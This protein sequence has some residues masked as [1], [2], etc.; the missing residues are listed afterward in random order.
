M[1]FIEQHSAHTAECGV[2]LQKA[3]EQAIG[4]QLNPG[5]RAHAA[6]E[7]H[8]IADGVANGFAKGASHL[9]RGHLGRQPPRFKHQHLA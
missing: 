7:P 2:V 9:P 8:A 3:Q 4:E 1:H 5:V 6:V